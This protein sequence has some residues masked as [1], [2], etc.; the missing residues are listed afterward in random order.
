MTATKSSRVTIYI[1]DH[2]PA[3]FYLD[4]YGKETV[5]LGRGPV[6]GGQGSVNNDIV[7]PNEI[8]FVSRAH[9]TFYQSDG[10]WFIFDD[11]SANGLN[12]NGVK[13]F[14]QMMSDGDKYYIGKSVEERLVIAYSYG[15][16]GAAEPID[17]YQLNPNG[18]YVIGRDASC[19]LVLDHPSVS[20]WHC[21]ITG[22]N[23][24]FYAED[25]NSTNGIILNGAQL[26][27]KVKLNQMDKITIA[28]STLIFTDGMLYMQKL[29][30]GVSV[31]V[32]NVYKKVKTKKGEKFITNGVNLNI[33][34]GEFV[35]IVGGSGA[36]KTTI[37]NCISGMA[38]FSAGDIF[39]NG[40]S[41]KTN[42]RSLRSLMGYV[43]QND[44]VYDN[45][46]LERMLMY[47][48]KLRMPVD[49]TPAEIQD[50]IDETLELVELTAHRT[51]MISRLSG[52][53]K[54]RA[55]I[56]VEL[57]ASPKLFFLDEP[58]SGLDPGTEKHLMQMLKKLSETGKTV[59]MVTHTV[60]NINVCDRL[61]CMGNG[62]VLC[63]SGNPAKALDFFGK[64]DMIDIY[65]DLNENSKAVSERFAAEEA[66]RNPGGNQ[67]I[68]EKDVPKARY[69]FVPKKFFKQF[70]VMTARYAEIIFNS[71][72]RLL[73]LLIMPIALT[74]LV[75]IA[76]QAD[77]NI[78]NYLKLSVDRDCLPFLVAGDTMKLMFAFSC[79]AFWIGIFNSV[80]EISKERNIFEREK[81]TG[82]RAVPYVLSKFVIIGII[83]LV[84]T[85]IMQLLFNFFSNTTATVDGNID[86][87]TA[88]PIKMNDGGIVFTSSL[89]MELFVTSFLCVMS[90]MCLGLLI[91]SA[92]SNDLALI[93]CPVFLL[94][95]ILF[96]GVA[97]TLSGITETI[98]KII[99]CRWA[100]IAYFTSSNINDMYE[101]AKFE[102]GGWELTEYETG[103]GVD[104]AYSAYKTY[105][106]SMNPTK[107]AWVVLAIMC[108]ICVIASMIILTVRKT[109]R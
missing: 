33:E 74:A 78:Y 81:F 73:M 13:I 96:S 24:E 1:P 98:S 18:K 75:C 89:P 63:Y 79:A 3:V 38:E 28:D 92:A 26:R 77:G 68:E 66:K 41:I 36:G 16:A 91:S 10:H 27:G 47:S 50:K 48:A 8:A 32:R 85:V 21:V 15:E 108:V 56:A 88:L 106:G 65:D 53:Q 97:S 9:C 22:V 40:E 71:R 90:A 11:N 84:Q 76:F 94:P 62:G 23:G 35:A 60:Q 44:I 4:S 107:S 25:N 103:F 69:A 99:P 37:L 17:K 5:R 100:C 67:D 31:S 64:E 2:E 58:S 45:L 109:K 49:T 6:H 54:K 87:L 34:P 72:S 101:S 39:I 29:K 86:S 7:I 46:T 57:L 19:N 82:V 43:P 42:E 52:G 30:S 104:E 105:V 14:S 59:I 93:L 70:F 61:I 102:V 55:S 95:Q 80:Q 51:T 83:C 20:R 12:F